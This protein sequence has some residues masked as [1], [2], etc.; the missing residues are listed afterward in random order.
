MTTHFTSGANEY[1]REDVVSLLLS[2]DEGAYVT[3][4]EVDVEDTRE[5]LFGSDS[6]PGTPAANA[7]APP[8]SS[9]NGTRRSGNS[10]ARGNNKRKRQFISEESADQDIVDLDLR[11]TCQF[12]FESCFFGQPDYVVKWTQHGCPVHEDCLLN[13]VKHAVEVVLTDAKDCDTKLP[14]KCPSQT[15][16]HTLTTSDVINTC[17]SLTVRSFVRAM[18]KHKVKQAVVQDDTKKLLMCSAGHYFAVAKSKKKV[19][20]PQCR[21]V[22]CSHCG[23]DASDPLRH[24]ACHTVPA[25]DYL[26]YTKKRELKSSDLEALMHCFNSR[27]IHFVIGRCPK[28]QKGV[29]KLEQSCLH[30]TCAC[31]VDFCFVCKRLLANNF[32]EYREAIAKGDKSYAVYPE[33]HALSSADPFM[34]YQPVSS[35]DIRFDRRKPLESEQCPQMPESLLNLYPVDFLGPLLSSNERGV[36]GLQVFLLGLAVSPFEEL[37]PGSVFRYLESKWEDNWGILDKVKTS[38]P[39]FRFTTPLRFALD[40]FHSMTTAA[41]SV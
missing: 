31:G 10:R 36:L 22:V 15:C 1:A 11:V 37:F 40:M 2:D 38:D 4:H 26:R 25:N 12:C 33:E 24:R 9:S 29:H 23:V 30:M 16:Q 41:Q 34:H 17:D 6:E 3:D 21:L 35:E 19:L 7:R 18:Q 39:R 27:I 32:D 20:C 5:A 8:S 28:C 14:L 13:L